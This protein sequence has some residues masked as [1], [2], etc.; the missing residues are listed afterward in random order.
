MLIAADP[1]VLSV[2]HAGKQLGISEDL[3]YEL[4]RRGDYLG[5]FASVV[6]AG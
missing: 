3:A 4:A 1:N 2:P 5:P 6:I